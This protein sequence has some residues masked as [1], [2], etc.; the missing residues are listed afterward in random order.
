MPNAAGSYRRRYDH[1]HPAARRARAECLARSDDTCQSCGELKATEG[2]HWVYPLE[3]DTTGNHLTALCGHCHDLITWYV[4]F[5]SLGGSRQLLGEIFPAFLSRLLDR[6]D[7]PETG[8]VGRARRVRHAWG[9][10]VSGAS[11]PC[12]G[13]V[14]AVL[15]RCSRL[16]RDVVVVEVVDGRPGSWLVLTRW[17]RTDEEVRPVCVADLRHDPR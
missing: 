8:R 1:R 13:E 3:E 9:A 5:V 6:R 2:H 14:V 12:V 15:L 4:R 16:W 11:R 7:R 17:R 10:V